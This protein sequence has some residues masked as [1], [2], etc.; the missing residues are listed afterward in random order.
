MVQ[1]KRRKTWPD[2]SDRMRMGQEG[3]HTLTKIKSFRINS[4]FREPSMGLS[5][6]ISLSFETNAPRSK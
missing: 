6:L 2:N 4:V 3:S 5:Q 1:I